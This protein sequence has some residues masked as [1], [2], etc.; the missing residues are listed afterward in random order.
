LKFEV[1]EKQHKLFTNL[2]SNVASFKVKL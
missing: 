2:C 1:V